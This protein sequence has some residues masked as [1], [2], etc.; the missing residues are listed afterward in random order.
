MKSEISA[1]FTLTGLD[2]EPEEITTK[3]KI[4]PTKIWRKGDLIHPQTKLT[5]KH[6]GWS[7][8]S[9]V[10]QSSDLEDH[11]NSIFSY[12]PSNWTDLME[13]CQQYYAEINC[14]IY[15]VGDERP[16]IHL[17]KNIIRKLNKLNAE[18][19]ID[20]YFLPDD[21]DTNKSPNHQDLEL[22]KMAEKI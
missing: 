6:N 14:V 7:L 10:D 8:Q 5:R 15:V 16:A 18:I 12:F 22:V 20:L 11:I 13:I 17:D 4:K 9:Q 3:L 19:D 1:Y 2:F 21:S